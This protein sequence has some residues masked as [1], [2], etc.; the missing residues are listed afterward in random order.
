MKG[1]LKNKNHAFHTPQKT[2]EQWKNTDTQFRIFRGPGKLQIT[3]TRGT[4]E[5]CILNPAGYVQTG[6]L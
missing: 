5:F 3:E 6:R 1:W 4:G 2:K